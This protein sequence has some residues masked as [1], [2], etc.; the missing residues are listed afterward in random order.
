MPKI[1]TLGLLAPRFPAPAFENYN[2]KRKIPEEGI[3]INQEDYQICSVN[4]HYPEVYQK[5]AELTL[6]LG[7][8][9]SKFNHRFQS[10]TMQN[11]N[12]NV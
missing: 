4:R 6:S 12:G 11:F 2:I 8:A 9:G 5:N 7:Y 1:R 10:K 3:I